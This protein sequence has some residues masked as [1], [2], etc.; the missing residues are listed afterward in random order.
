ME[1]KFQDDEVEI[2]LKELFAILMDKILWILLAGV[3]CALAVFL[4]TR[5]F[6]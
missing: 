1:K 3:V 4:V 5:F 6:L 2:D